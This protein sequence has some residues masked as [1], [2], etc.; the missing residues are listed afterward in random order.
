MANPIELMLALYIR[1]ALSTTGD[2]SDEAFLREYKVPSDNAGLFA[3]L[4]G[5]S[6]PQEDGPDAEVLLRRLGSDDFKERE[7]ASA[8]IVQLE[9]KALPAL[10]RAVANNDDPEIAQRAKPCIDLI[11]WRLRVPLARAVVRLLL[12]RH[13]PGIEAALLE[14]LPYADETGVEEDICF[15]LYDLAVQK[16]A[17]DTAFMAAL[18]DRL[19]ARRALAACLVA[20]LGDQTQRGRVKELLRDRDLRVRLRAAQELLAAKDKVGLPALI[21]LLADAP[22]TLAWQAEELLHWVA[23]DNAPEDTLGAGLP[24]ARQKCLQAWR[25]WWQTNERKLDLIQK[26]LDCWLP[27]MVLVTNAPNHDQSTKTSQLCLFGC[28]GRPRWQMRG[29]PG[30]GRQ[31]WQ[32]CAYP[33]ADDFLVL[34]GN[35]FLVAEYDSQRFTERDLMGKILRV[36]KWKAEWPDVLRATPQWECPCCN[37]R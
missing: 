22:I 14:Y 24:E 2:N 28:N 15:G 37:P 30:L 34:P 31:R 18:E 26:D 17:L 36:V 21:S 25:A 8:Q 33:G 13:L 7:A 32:L 35:R 12:T 3:F 27:G 11:E 16:R 23:G 6:G 29:L 20:R 19:P 9:A 4:R 5:R 10:R 1:I